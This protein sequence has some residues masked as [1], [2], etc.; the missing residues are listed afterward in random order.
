MKYFPVKKYSLMYPLFAL[1]SF[2]LSSCLSKNANVEPGKNITEF[3][4]QGQDQNAGILIIP[5]DQTWQIYPEGSEVGSPYE[6]QV[7]QLRKQLVAGAKSLFFG[8]NKA[9]DFFAQTQYIV[10]KRP[11]VSLDDYSSFLMR[12]AYGFVK[13]AQ[14]LGKLETSGGI[15]G[16]L[17]QYLTE[18]FIYFELIYRVEN[19]FLRTMISTPVSVYKG[20]DDFAMGKNYALGILKEISTQDAAKRPQKLKRLKA[21][22]KRR[23]KNN[24]KA[25]PNT[26]ENTQENIQESAQKNTKA[27]QSTKQPIQPTKQA[28]PN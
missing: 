6:A 10:N 23:A 18:D 22:P 14:N 4:L 28:E 12:T 15:Q 16:Q 17:L 24:A 7:S 9:E 21:K 5:F 3:P 19:F 13:N 1:L 20:H 26:Q 27:E 8:A 11:N 2:I 25:P